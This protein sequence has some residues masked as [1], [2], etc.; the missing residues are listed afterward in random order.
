MA[1]ACMAET[2]LLALEHRYEHTS[3]GRDLNQETLETLRSLASKHGFALAEL[4]SRGRPL[5]PAA[6]ARRFLR[7]SAA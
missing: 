4:R 5:N 7:S 2:M 3:L 6:W 1:Y